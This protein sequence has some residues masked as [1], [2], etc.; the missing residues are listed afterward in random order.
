[1][2]SIAYYLRFYLGCQTD[3]GRLIGLDSNMAYTAS[4]DGTIYGHD[5]HASD[6]S[7]KPYLKRL[8][9]LTESQSLELI[10][11][12]FSI[13]RPKGYSFSPGAFLYLLSLNVDLFGLI[14]VGWAEEEG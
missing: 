6:F 1:M 10:N 3:K 11:Q 2:K 8:S 12:G 4:G 9:K 7:I 14:D 5:I 13:G